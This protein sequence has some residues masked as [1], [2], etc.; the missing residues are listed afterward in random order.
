M[1]KILFILSL[2]ILQQVVY[3]QSTL[4]G[5]VQSDQ[6][7]GVS[8]VNVLNESQKTNT[9]T[10][11]NGVFT[12]SAKIG[13]IVKFSS[14]G[15]RTLTITVKSLDNLVIKLVNEDAEIEEVV[16]VGY[17]AIK[18][19]NLTGSVSR[20]DKKVLETGV[21]SNPASALAGTIPGLRVQQVSGRPGAVPNIVLRGGTS[22]DGSGSPL[23]IVDG[24]VRGGFQ[25]INPADIESIDVL[26]DASATAIYGAR[27]SNGVILITTKRGKEGV[28]SI[29]ARAKVG[30]NTINLPF[31]FLNAEDYLYWTRKSVQVS[32]QYQP[33]QLNQLT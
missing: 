18:K 7:S 1:R 13:D 2:C 25:D 12:I 15:Y 21:R 30:V 6:G 26:K 32:G 31:E 33:S 5:L 3:A 11:S 17:G 4:K 10:N 24:V 16:V 22:Y 19:S 14:V 9:D 8:G 29:D 23:I 28:S 20:L 27:A